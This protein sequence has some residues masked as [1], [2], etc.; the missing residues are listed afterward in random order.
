MQKNRLK[1]MPKSVHKPIQS[2]LKAIKK[3]LEV[4]DKQLDKLVS[5]IA[6]WRQKR[7]LLLSAKGSGMCWPTP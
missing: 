7:D 3:E 6:E 5:S 2:I 4:I 1:R